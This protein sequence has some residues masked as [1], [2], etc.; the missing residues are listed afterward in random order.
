MAQAEEG[1]S[2]ATHGRALAQIFSQGTEIPYNAL[3]G[4]FLQLATPQATLAYAESLAAVEY[5]HDT[6]GM[7]DVPR[8][9]ERLAQGSSSEAALRATIHADYRQL[10][11]DLARWL[12]D[13]YG[14]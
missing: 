13:K 2:S 11:D 3:E 5:I 8:I 9:L 7:S 4:S 14:E 6:Y 1:R 12:K 10:R